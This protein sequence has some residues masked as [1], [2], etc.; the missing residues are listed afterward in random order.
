MRVSPN[1]GYFDTVFYVDA[2]QSQ[3]DLVGILVTVSSGEVQVANINYPNRVISIRL[4]DTVNGTKTVSFTD[5]VTT[6]TVDIILE[7]PH[8]PETRENYTIQDSKRPKW[9]YRTY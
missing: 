1:H 9:P 5:G 7:T 2:S 4:T 6:E 8:N 3:M